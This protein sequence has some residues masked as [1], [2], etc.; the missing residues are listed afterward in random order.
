[1]FL[2]ENAKHV[3]FTTRN[4]IASFASIKDLLYIDEVFTEV[5]NKEECRGLLNLAPPPL[6]TL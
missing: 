4:A 2:R 6:Y 3:L 1:M 5:T